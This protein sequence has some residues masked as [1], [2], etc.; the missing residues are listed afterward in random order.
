MEAADTVVLPE[1]PGIN[2]ADGLKRVAGNRRLYRDLLEQFAAKQGDAANQISTALE[3]GD[4]KLAERIAHTIK[5]VAGNIGIT[6][7]ESAAEKLESAL[8]DGD[9]NVR[10]LLIEF[11]PL[12]SAQVHS[13]EIALRDSATARPEK[14]RASPFNA[15]AAAGA[16]AQLKILLET[17]DG[18]AE[19]SFRGLQDAVTGAVEKQQLDRLSASIN[20]FDFDAALV[21]LDE[22]AERLHAKW[23]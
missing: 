17:S 16:I 21:K 12:M 7:V 6:E 5:G 3:R 1:I 14:P 23:G 20:E 2:V 11:A 8:H 9:G 19:E 4:L 15:E 10:A 18:D 22:I 13:I